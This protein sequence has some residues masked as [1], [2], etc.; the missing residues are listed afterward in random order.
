MIASKPRCLSYIEAA[1]VPAVA[2]TAWQMVLD[3]G[4]VE[5]TRRVLVRGAAGNVAAYAVQLAK[6]AG[7]QVIATTFSRDVDFIHTL[8][9]DQIIDV[10]KVP[11][12]EQVQ[13][14]DVVID[15]VGGETLARSFEVI[16]PGGVL[17]SSVIMP[18]QDKAAQHHVRGIFF[19]V[20]VTSEGLKRIAD[21]LDS[22]Q[23]RTN[24]GEGVAPRQ[25]VPGTR[26]ARGKTPQAGE[27][28]RGSKRMKQWRY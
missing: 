24:V 7:A 2:S 21:L 22:G 25:S 17:V 27:D 16:K 4:Q 11:F 6:R 8:G 14:V 15:T 18:D 13:D 23:L 26:D 19:L 12:E 20:A 5:G 9:A 10:K 28:R 1:S 3:H